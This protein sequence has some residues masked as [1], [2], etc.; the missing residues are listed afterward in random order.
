LFGTPYPFLL[1]GGEIGADGFGLALHRFGGN[2]Q[3]GQQGQLVTAPLK[4]GLTA[5]QRHH[6]AD[7][8]GEL[9]PVHVEFA[10]PRAVPGMALR[11]GR[12]GPFQLHR[13]HGREHSFGAVI[14]IASLPSARAVYRSG[15][16]AALPQQSCQHRGPGPMQASA[17][18]HL[19]RFQ[20]ERMPSALGRQHYLEKRPD[21]PCGFLM[22]SSSRF[23]SAS[24]QPVGSAAA[25]RNQQIRSLRPVRSAL[26]S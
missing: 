20:I 7:T 19:D 9:M 12:I 17:G 15:V 25:G 14:V 1:A 3:S 6:A 8:W 13:S 5:C 23:F 26:S 21:F 4:A 18:G 2:L 10:V 22:N 16:A 24:V 11:A